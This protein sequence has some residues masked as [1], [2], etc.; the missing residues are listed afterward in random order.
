MKMGL[1]YLTYVTTILFFHIHIFLRGAIPGHKKRV[2]FCYTFGWGSRPKIPHG[3]WSIRFERHCFNLF[4]LEQ[5]SANQ[6]TLF[7]NLIK[8]AIKKKNK[9]ETYT[10]NIFHKF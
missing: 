5:G 8:N 7:S 3:R 2:V 9:T 4:N 6:I 10:G 1:L